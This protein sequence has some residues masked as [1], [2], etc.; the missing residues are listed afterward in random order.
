MVGVG[1][2][3]VAIEGGVVALMVNVI[4]GGITAAMV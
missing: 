1:K 2:V 4:V 3:K